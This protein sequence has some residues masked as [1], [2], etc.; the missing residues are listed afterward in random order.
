MT[1]HMLVWCTITVTLKVFGTTDVDDF[2]TVAQGRI[3]KIQGEDMWVDFSEYARKQG[4][5]GDKYYNVHVKDYEC[6]NAHE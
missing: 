5:I 3:T 1:L 2:E 6:A 4:Y